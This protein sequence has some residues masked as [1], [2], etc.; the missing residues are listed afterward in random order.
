[1][2][3]KIIQAKIAMLR[4]EL[5]REKKRLKLFM[6]HTNITMCFI[7]VAFALHL[8][9]GC[10]DTEVEREYTWEDYCE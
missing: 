1:M 5:E 4:E 9:S 2:E 10:S 8:C 3:D 7:A 6:W